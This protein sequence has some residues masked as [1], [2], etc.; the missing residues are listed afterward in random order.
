MIAYYRFDISSLECSLVI[1]SLELASR[2]LGKPVRPPGAY[3]SRGTV[4]P[5]TCAL[6]PN[7]ALLDDAR[8]PGPSGIKHARL[9]R[10]HS[11]H[12]IRMS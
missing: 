8:A 2:C 10:P 9:R 12:R 1:S 4:Q 5:V 3:E 11:C 7:P 6:S